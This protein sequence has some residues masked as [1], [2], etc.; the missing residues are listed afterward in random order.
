MSLP[1]KPPTTPPSF[2]L[3]F[4]SAEPDLADLITLYVTGT[5]NT[6]IHTQTYT[7]ICTVFA[8]NCVDNKRAYQLRSYIFSLMM[9]NRKLKLSIHVQLLH[10]LC[11]FVEICKNTLSSC[12]VFRHYFSHFSDTYIYSLYLNLFVLPLCFV[13]TT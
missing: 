5:V 12:L 13:Y 4:L 9:S 10:L 8:L 1:R 7:N 2:S 11:Y 3:L 6:R